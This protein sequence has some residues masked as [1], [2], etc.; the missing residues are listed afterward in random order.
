MHTSRE[1]IHCTTPS[2]QQM[3]L[4]LKIFEI[5]LN[6]TICQG[7]GCACGRCGKLCSLSDHES[8][9]TPAA[10]SNAGG[11][12]IQIQRSK[13]QNRCKLPREGNELGVHGL[14]KTSCK[15]FSIGWHVLIFL[16]PLSAGGQG[17]RCRQSI[18]TR[19]QNSLKDKEHP[20]QRKRL[21]N[22]VGGTRNRERRLLH[23]SEVWS[24]LLSHRCQPCR[25]A[26]PITNP[27]IAAS[28]DSS[29]LTA[30]E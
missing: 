16:R 7:R 4:H 6:Y 17:S 19:S 25:E 30:P 23:I 13:C 3:P 10:W 8:R 21:A 15:Q 1:P 12:G 28:D 5:L 27:V 22:P 2:S 11:V 9:T 29:Y 20:R 26:E 24:F 18:R 14:S